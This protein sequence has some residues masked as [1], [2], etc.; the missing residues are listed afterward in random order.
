M[1]SQKCATEPKPLVLEAASVKR[2]TI[3]K[4]IEAARVKPWIPDSVRR[5]LDRLTHGLYYA[6]SDQVE[7]GRSWP[8]GGPFLRSLCLGSKSNF[9]GNVPTSQRTR[10]LRK[11]SLGF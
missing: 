5:N 9:A 3:H 11:V 1:R 10:P 2:Q 7:D 8:L 4:Y 6:R